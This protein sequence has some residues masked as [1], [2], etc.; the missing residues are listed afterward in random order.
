MKYYGQDKEGNRVLND[1]KHKVVNMESRVASAHQ[2]AR[3]LSLLVSQK[4]YGESKR[5]RKFNKLG[6]LVLR[7]QE[8][9]WNAYYVRPN[10]I[11]GAILIGSIKISCVTENI[12]LKNDFLQLMRD[13]VHDLRN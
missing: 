10:S 7:P 9:D 12:R 5:N 2:S 13:V 11:Y 3:S 6:R 4:P 1:S 8:D